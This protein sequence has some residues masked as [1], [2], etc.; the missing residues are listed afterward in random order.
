MI[1]LRVAS[2]SENISTRFVSLRHLN[3]FLGMSKG[4]RQW[5]QKRGRIVCGR[6]V[7]SEREGTLGN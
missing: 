7:S 6:V 3:A 4:C 1:V 5:T 2:K